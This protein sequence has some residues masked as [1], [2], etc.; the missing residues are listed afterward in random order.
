MNLLAH[1]Y[2]SGKKEQ[3]ITGNFI[4]DY[5]KGDQYKNYPNEVMEGI[6]LH[7]NIDSF[8][9][10]HDIVKHS[11]SYLSTYY[12]K[13]AG[14]VVDIFY[15]HFLSKDWDQFSQDS[16]YTFI[17]RIYRILDK[18]HFMLPEK[19]LQFFPEMK[20]Q[21]WLENYGTLEGISEV[22]ERIVKRARLP[23]KIK[24]ATQHLHEHY[25]VFHKDFYAFFPRII[26]YVRRSHHIAI[27]LPPHSKVTLQKN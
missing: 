26:N 2:L 19:V 25:D 24:H 14:V 9:D 13:Y 10:R 11:R 16:L 1:L 12:Q 21:R 5:V 7:R 6:M 8:T 20:H 15:D 17:N 27:E 18:Y 3:I 22:L 4:G 23:E